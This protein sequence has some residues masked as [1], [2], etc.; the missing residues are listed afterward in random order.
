MTQRLDNSRLD[1]AALLARASS[2]ATKNRLSPTCRAIQNRANPN[3]VRRNELFPSGTFPRTSK[4]LPLPQDERRALGAMVT[5]RRRYVA[6]GRTCP[7]KRT[8]AARRCELLTPPS[9]PRPGGAPSAR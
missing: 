5:P 1:R 3:P 4:R 7:R 6:P 9:L 8:C 2:S